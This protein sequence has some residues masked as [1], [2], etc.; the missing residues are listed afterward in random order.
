M[1]LSLIVISLIEQIALFCIIILLRP[2]IRKNFGSSWIEICWAALLIRIVF[3]ILKINNFGLFSLID[4]RKWNLNGINRNFSVQ[5]KIQKT[6]LADNIT[7]PD[8]F[9]PIKLSMDNFWIIINLVIICISVSVLVFIYYLTLKKLSKNKKEI[10]N[11]SIISEFHQGCSLF[12]IK[13]PVKV[14]ISAIKSPVLVGIFNPYV[15]IPQNVCCLNL[16]DITAIAIHETAHLCRKDNIKIIGIILIRCFFW[17]NPVVHLLCR[18]WRSDI[19]KGCD[20]LVLKNKEFGFISQYLNSLTNI[21]VN[22]QS[23][24]SSVFFSYM[25]RSNLLKKRISELYKWNMSFRK[26]RLVV[27]L[28]FGT[29]LFFL[30]SGTTLSTRREEQVDYTLYIPSFI[31][32]DFQIAI[33][34]NEETGFFVN[35]PLAAKKEVSVS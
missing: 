11:L 14:F 29:V 4:Y 15:Y 26:P 31:D 7:D 23:S 1:N 12:Q 17:Y 27:K 22:L 33:W 5:D 32:E 25:S 28:I 9:V 18:E 30:L 24:H 34:E 13:K 8:I 21:A 3:P 6:D 16:K 20:E 35:N 19:E 2:F 10:C